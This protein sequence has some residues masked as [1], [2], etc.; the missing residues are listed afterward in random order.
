M[1]LRPG[2][3]RHDDR[4]AG[5]GHQAFNNLAAAKKE[6]V[7]HVDMYY[8]AGHPAVAEPHYHV[9]IWYVS[10][11]GLALPRAS[12]RQWAVR[13]QSLS[14]TLRRRRGTVRTERCDP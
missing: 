7:D 1:G 14:A 9:L 4:T 5:D 8:N 13:G 3:R 6:E 11:A 10:L 12:F 2:W